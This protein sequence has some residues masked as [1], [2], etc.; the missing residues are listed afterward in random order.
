LKQY[1][2][3]L[4]DAH[5]EIDGLFNSLHPPSVWL[6]FASLTDW[7]EMRSRTGPSGELEASVDDLKFRAFLDRR[8]FTSAL[9]IPVKSADRIAYLLKFFAIEPNHFSDTEIRAYLNA[10]SDVLSLAFQREAMA[11]TVIRQEKRMKFRQTLAHVSDWDMSVRD[12][13]ISWSPEFFGLSKRLASL[14]LKGF[15]NLV[16]PDDQDSFLREINVSINGYIP[17]SFEFRL[18]VAE[19]S[20]IWLQMRGA[21]VI[22][23]SMASDDFIATLIDV[24]HAKDTEIKL[25][26][27]KEAADHASE[28]K[29]RFLSSMSH[30]LRTPLNSIL[31]F[32]Q[33][34]EIDTDLSDSHRE[35]LAEI[36]EAGRHLLNLINEVLDLSVV[37]SGVMNI[38]LQNTAAAEIIEEAVAMVMPTARRN[39]I[40]VSVAPIPDLY[41]LVDRTKFKQ[42]LINL[43]SNAIKY[44]KRQGSVDVSAHLT[45]NGTLRISVADT[46]IGIDPDKSSELFKPFNRLGQENS[47]RE[48][49]G[50][51]LNLAQKIV[52]MMAG[53]LGYYANQ[54]EGTTFYMDF[55]ATAPNT[56]LPRPAWQRKT[57]RS[58]NRTAAEPPS[59]L[60]PDRI[61]LISENA[62]TDDLLRGMLALSRRVEIRSTDFNNDLASLTAQRQPNIVIIDTTGEKDR[63]L[64]DAFFARLAEQTPGARL[65]GLVNPKH[66]TRMHN[67]LCTYCDYVCLSPLDPSTVYTVIQSL[68]V[69]ATTRGL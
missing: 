13:Q 22:D 4:A 10:L 8:G 57:I 26:R 64:D 52:S 38:V 9:S 51:G 35:N 23:K 29:S 42:A 60:H 65:V 69:H 33:L 19:Q 3:I 31:G 11:R 59:V 27:A 58:D 48:G 24:T 61:L 56:R 67:L 17:T 16:H 18:L 28:E 66:L 12:S 44:N 47:S 53:T 32:G 43:L 20:I 30:E 54:T 1:P 68:S 63:L 40:S 37:E 7:D 45:Q 2:T 15:I 25:L 21:R 34:L 55:S 39:S 41:L 50:I 46:G 14:S 6:K 62:A 5:M 36:I 49:T